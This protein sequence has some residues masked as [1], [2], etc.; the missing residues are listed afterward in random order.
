MK[1]RHLNLMIEPYLILS[2]I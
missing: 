2:Q 1:S